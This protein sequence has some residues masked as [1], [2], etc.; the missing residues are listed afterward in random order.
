METHALGGSST[1]VTADSQHI[2]QMD[3]GKRTPSS[4]SSQEAAHEESDSDFFARLSEGE[5]FWRDR[6]EL[7]ESRGFRLRPRYRPG[8]IPSWTVTGEERALCEDAIP[9][10]VS[11]PYN[12]KSSSLNKVS[13]RVS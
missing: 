10:G 7:F 4:R 12:P 1:N 13:V 11:R 6:F 9:Y 8:W 2:E 3:G 5:V